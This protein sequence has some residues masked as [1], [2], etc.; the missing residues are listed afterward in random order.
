M[1]HYPKTPGFTGTL[2]P[3]GRAS[4]LLMNSI[5]HLDFTSGRQTLWI[6]AQRIAEGPFA[7][8][9][10]PFRLRPALH[11]NWADASRIPASNPRTH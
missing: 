4:G 9:K 1:A 2:R 11:G 6:D 7:R 5:A 10:L 8:A 3:G